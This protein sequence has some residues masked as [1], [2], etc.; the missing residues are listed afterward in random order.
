MSRIIVRTLGLSLA[1]TATAGCG[2]GPPPAPPPAQP[3]VTLTYRAVGVSGGPATPQRID[4]AAVIVR[5]R[6]AALGVRPGTVAPSGETIRITVPAAKKAT[7][8]EGGVTS[9]G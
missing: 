1:L 7:V 5:R 2:G 8:T 9:R 4:R 6:L 3:A